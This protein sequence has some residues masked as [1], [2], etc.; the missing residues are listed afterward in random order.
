G[1]ALQA[2]RPED[3]KGIYYQMLTDQRLPLNGVERP[4]LSEVEGFIFPNHDTGRILPAESQRNSTDLVVTVIDSTETEYDSTDESSA[5]STS[6]SPLKKPCDVEPVS[7]PK[8]VKTTLKSISTFKT[9]ALKVSFNLEDV[10]LN[11]NNKVALLYP[12]HSNKEVF[13]CVSDF[14]S[15]CC[16]REAFTR[17]PIQYKENLSEFWYSAKA[18]D[19]SKVSFLIPTGRIYRELWVNIFRKAMGA[20]YL[21]HSSDYVDPHSINIVRPWFSTIGYEE[22]VSTK[23][24]LKKSLLPPRWRLLMGQIIQCLWGKTEG[25][26]QITNKD[27]IILYCLA[28]GVNIDYAMIFWED[29]INKLK[30]KNKEKVV[31]CKICI[32][33]NDAKDEGWVWR[34]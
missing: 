12:G 19:N 31:S 15:K 8:T 23:G 13:L 21:S 16:I 24:T 20:H 2:K 25:F 30:K 17:S 22:E 3:Q 1:G 14:V 26:D 5:C 33:S 27:A 18:L 10:I 9:E 34:W 11:T 29:I 32:P 28:N 7:G 4:W 6:F